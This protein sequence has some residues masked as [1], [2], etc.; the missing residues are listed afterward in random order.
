MFRT[1]P[2]LVLGLS[3]LNAAHAQTTYSWNFGT[4]G[5]PQAGI[6]GQTG[7]PPT[8]AVG[9]FSIGNSFGT[10]TTPINVTSASSGY[11]GATGQMN[12]GNACAVGSL[13]PGTSAFFQ[14]T[15]MP[16]SG[17]AVQ[18]SDISFGMRSASNGPQAYAFRS[19]TD[20]FSTDIAY[21]TGSITNNSTWALKKNS[22]LVTFG[23]NETVTL[24]LFLFGGTG[25]PTAGTIN[26]RM[27]DFFITVN[28]VNPVPEPATCLGLAA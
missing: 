17:L 23:V 11:T 6:T 4:T 26:N 19:S 9:S 20:F 27:D 2:A 8:V 5:S 25:T 10:V 14:I 18:I 24:R 3:V 15:L 22:P 13:N 16:D 1:L 12:I 21:A 28:G 7:S